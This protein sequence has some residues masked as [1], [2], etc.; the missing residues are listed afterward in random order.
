MR[1]TIG[2]TLC[3]LSAQMIFAQQKLTKS[4]T[5]TQYQ[6]FLKQ[7]VL[8][9]LSVTFN[10]SAMTPIKFRWEKQNQKIILEGYRRGRTLTV[11]AINMYGEPE[12]IF[13]TP[14]YIDPIPPS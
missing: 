3:L 6:I 1:K 4:P 9:V 12:E 7:P 14:C 11:H 13:Q 8:K 5:L 10:D 2:L